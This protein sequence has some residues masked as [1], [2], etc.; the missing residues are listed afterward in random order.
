MATVIQKSQLKDER[1]YAGYVLQH[2]CAITADQPKLVGK[3]DAKE[4]CFWFW[5]FEGNRK[6]KRKLFYLTDIANEIE[7]GFHPTKEIIPKE[8][9][10]IE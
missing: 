8:E 2:Y 9:Y 3:W 1:Y 7:H 10:V 4:Q 6:T 5:E